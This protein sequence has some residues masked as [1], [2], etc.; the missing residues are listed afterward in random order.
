MPYADP[1]KRRQNSAKWRQNNKEREKEYARN[2]YVANKE[3]YIERA[4]AQQR[5]D[6]DKHRAR[7]RQYRRRASASISDAYVRSVLF[8][9]GHRHLNEAQVDQ[10]VQTKRAL[11]ALE[12]EI[13]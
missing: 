2:Y 13:R 1:E 3:K 7:M 11:I 12:R 6:P 4:L 5:Q 8:R 9:N 10:L